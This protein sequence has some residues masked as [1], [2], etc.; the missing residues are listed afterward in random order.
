MVVIRLAGALFL[1]W[2]GAGFETACRTRTCEI[3]FSQYYRET[4][5]S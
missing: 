4:Q 1:G 2:Q 3:A 5:M